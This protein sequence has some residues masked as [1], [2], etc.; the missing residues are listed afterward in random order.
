[1]APFAAWLLLSGIHTLPLRMSRHCQNAYR[2]ACVMANHPAV[3]TVHY[4]G[5]S[6]D[7]GHALASTLVGNGNDRFGGMMSV[8]LAGGRAAFSPFLDSLELCTI[9]VSLGDC[10]TL[11]WPWHRDN[12]IRFSVG[13]EDIVDLERDVVAALERLISVA[14]AD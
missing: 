6:T 7:P 2:L 4:P 5:L 8:A 10:S 9:A 1:M 11:V 12:L 13:L 3:E 14:A